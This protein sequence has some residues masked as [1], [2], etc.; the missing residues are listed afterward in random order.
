[1]AQAMLG[2]WEEAA[3]DLH[4]ASKLDYD[5]EIRNVLKKVFLLIFSSY[6]TEYCIHHSG[7]PQ[8]TWSFLI[9]NV[10]LNARFPV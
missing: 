2:Q 3:K 8:F 7:F 5:E 10:V 6:L 9:T 4:L 1:M